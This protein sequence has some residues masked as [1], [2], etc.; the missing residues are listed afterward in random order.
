MDAEPSR[1]ALLSLVALFPVTAYWLAVDGSFAP[2]LA[3]VNVLLIAGSLVYMTR[4]GDA[5]AAH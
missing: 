5:A 2:L 1:I 4:G 3:V